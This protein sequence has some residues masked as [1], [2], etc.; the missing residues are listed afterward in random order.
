[1]TRSKLSE[2]LFCAPLSRPYRCKLSRK[3]G[4]KLSRN[5][6][7]KLSRQLGLV[8]A[9]VVS[10]AVSGCMAPSEVNF[11]RY[12]LT[13][14]VAPE[15]YLNDYDIKL[16]LAP[17]LNQGGVVLQMSDVTLRPAKN[18]RY[19]ANLGDE[20]TL[21]LSDELH[22]ANAP[23]NL[24]YEAYVAKFQGT[25]T[26][27]ALVTVAFRVRAQAEPVTAFS[28]IRQRG[29][30]IELPVLWGKAYEHNSTISA[31]GYSALV[32]ALKTNFRVVAQS[33]AQ[34]VNRELPDG[35][36]PKTARRARR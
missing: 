30:S 15:A 29:E 3:L 24:S 19:S 23:R 7:C 9:V 21:L 20:L 34:D 27:E 6:S 32:Q 8:A 25:T 13:Q 35:K 22:Q 36:P 17:I 31:D 1:M 2:N 4:C 11:E 33:F 16:S 18:F 28:A 12:T 14:D 10:C 26:G 5:L